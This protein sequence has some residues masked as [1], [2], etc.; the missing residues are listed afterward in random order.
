MSITA[1]IRHILHPVQGEIWCLHRVV[2]ERSSFPSN[3][4]L[5]ITP[6]YL[7]SL[8][9]SYIQRGFQFVSVE[10]IVSDVDRR[11]WDLRRK[12]RVAISFDDGF[13]DVYQNAFPIFKKYHVPFTIYLVGN[14]PEGQSDLWW[15]QMEQLSGS[16]IPAFEHLMKELYQAEDNMRDLMHQKTNSTPDL[17]LCEQLSLSWNQL[18][19]MVSSGLCTI[20]CHSMTHPGLTRIPKDQVQWELTESRRVI[21]SHLPVRV[22]HFSYPH[23][24]ESMDIQALLKETGYRSATLGYGG[25]VRKGD[26]LF[27]LNRRYIVQP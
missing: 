6:D 3:R 27:K 23:S 18:K 22:K 26:N 2:T 21:E 19:E 7:D 8:I 13:V 9:S 4:E 14:Y 16:D 1:K 17:N 5:E 12:K 11:P 20:G 10:D 25:T 24:M 15:I